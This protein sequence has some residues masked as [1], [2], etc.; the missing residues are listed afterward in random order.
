[1]NVL[2]VGIA[3]GI[4]KELFYGT[5]LVAA[6]NVLKL[7]GIGIVIET[8][9]AAALIIG[10]DKKLLFAR[11]IGDHNA[12]FI[13]LRDEAKH[14][15]AFTPFSPRGVVHLDIKVAGAFIFEVICGIL[16]L[17]L[18]AQTKQRRRIIDFYFARQ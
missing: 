13:T 15:A 4:N 1:M 7:F 9:T 10:L 12:I 14:I 8:R 11:E 18:K 2:D 17:F 6:P 5:V 16:L 3:V